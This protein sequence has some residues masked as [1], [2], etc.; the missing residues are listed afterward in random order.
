MS[1][2]VDAISSVVNAIGERRKTGQIFRGAFNTEIDW[3]FDEPEASEPLPD[4]EIR[5]VAIPEDKDS[6]PVLGI[7]GSS[8][9]FMTPYGGFALATLAV[10]LGRLPLLDYPPL[11]YRY[12]IDPQPTPFIAAYTN[13]N[14]NS[15]LV[16]TSSPSGYPYQEE[17]ASEGERR[18]FALADM[19]HE[20]RTILETHGIRLSLELLEPLSRSL[21]GVK[22]LLLLDGPLYQRPWRSQVLKSG[23]LR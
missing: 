3:F 20:I 7:D 18:S 9:R 19:A 11:H 8:R 4:T 22:P 23:V 5:K 13:L 14:V 21:G 17:G 16:R 1:Q 12:I 6:M 15:S 10:S 2:A